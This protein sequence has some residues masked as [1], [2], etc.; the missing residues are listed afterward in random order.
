VSGLSFLASVNPPT[1]LERQ[2]DASQILPLAPY[3]ILLILENPL[4]YT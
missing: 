1:R 3:K 4:A 2:L